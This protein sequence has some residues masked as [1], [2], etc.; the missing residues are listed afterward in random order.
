[1][2]KKELIVIKIGS[3]VL[4]DSN[5]RL[6][7]KS[8]QKI[9]A[10]IKHFY[11]YDKKIII[12]SSGAIAC[13]TEKLKLDHE[14][15]TIPQKQAA[16]SVGQSLLMENYRRCLKPIDVGQILLTAD[17]IKLKPRAENITNTINEL[18]KLKVVPIINENDSVVVD[19]IKFGEN[20]ILSAQVAGLVKA[21]RLIILT[22]LDGLYDKNPRKNP[23]AKL[24]RSV[25]AVTPDIQRLADGKGS[26]KGTGGMVSK[27]MAAKL[28]TSAGIDTYI[29]N[30]FRKNILLDIVL[31]KAVCTHFRAK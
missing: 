5:G 26:F 16:A 27:L 20:D 14:M 17:A 31:G 18:L 24:L 7:H 8:F 13:G 10:Q 1:M 2:H 23:E 3:N 9:A 11:K 28:A 25:A 21:D 29:A 4:T 30:G 15:R 22:D 19:E 6:S 12:V